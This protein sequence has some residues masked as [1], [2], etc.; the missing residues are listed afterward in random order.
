MTFVLNYNIFNYFGLWEQMGIML[1][2]TC[3]R[4]KKSGKDLVKR[5][6]TR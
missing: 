1:P 3:P 4:I 2:F 5:V 6:L